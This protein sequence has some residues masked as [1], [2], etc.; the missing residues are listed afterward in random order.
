MLSLRQI[1]HEQIAR[2]VRYFGGKKLVFW[3]IFRF[4][5]TMLNGRQLCA[6]MRHRFQFS[7]NLS[8]REFLILFSNPIFCNLLLF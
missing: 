1:F 7:A 6:Y 8:Q 2:N 5:K 3:R 4:L